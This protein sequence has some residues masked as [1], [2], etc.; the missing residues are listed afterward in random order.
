MKAAGVNI[1]GMHYASEDEAIEHLEDIQPDL[2]FI[3]S[4]WPETYCYTL[5]IP[6][7]R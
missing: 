1:T 7:L 4:V 3:A 5:S 2:V 6:R